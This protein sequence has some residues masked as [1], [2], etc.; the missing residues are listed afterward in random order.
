MQSKPTDRRWV[1]AIDSGQG[2]KK[3]SEVRAR[4]RGAAFRMLHEAHGGHSYW[5]GSFARV[6]LGSDLGGPVRIYSPREWANHV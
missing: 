6:L 3:H 5:S 4:S 2:Y 1:V